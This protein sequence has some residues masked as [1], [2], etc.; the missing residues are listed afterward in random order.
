M[1]RLLLIASCLIAVIADMLFVWYAKHSDHPLWALIVAFVLN[2][3]GCGIWMYTLR[4]GIESATAITFYALFTVAG[5]SL[6]GTVYFKEI[7]STTNLIGVVLGLIAL[8][9]LSV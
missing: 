4:N 3:I 7:L 6:L 8:I 5:C 9:L 1:N 2:T